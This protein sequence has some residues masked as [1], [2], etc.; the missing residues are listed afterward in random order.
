MD[1]VD[2][3]F[4]EGDGLPRPD[5]EAIYLHVEEHLKEEEQN[6]LW[7]DIART[8]MD[9]LIQQMEGNYARHES[10]NFI[11]VT[12]E[13]DRY[14]SL[15]LKFLEGNLKKIKSMLPGIVSDEGYGKYVVIVFDNDD[16][17]YNYVMWFYPEKGEFGG[18][19]GMYINRGY[20]HFVFPHEE[21]TYAESVAA[22][23]M[24][25]ALLV[26]LPIPLWLNEGL[27]VSVENAITPSFSERMDQHMHSRHQS[28]WGPEEIQQ[29]WSGDAF[30]RPDKGQELSYHLA[31][32]AVQTLSQDYDSFV[33]FV[34]K[35]NYEDAGENAATEVFGSSLGN[36]L[37]PFVGEGNWSPKPDVWP[38]AN[39]TKVSD[40]AKAK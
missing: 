3:Y 10:D 38:Q 2:K 32:F 8:W 31:Q 21:L 18:S 37:I 6:T 22:H 14:V 12:S 24:T 26:H 30:I 28:F 23:E 27:A 39:E 1:W 35:A 4:I 7:C 29:F 16:H 34:N 36:L 15:F 40:T 20:G 17:Y 19:S 25:H 5:W 13:D 33:Q 11:L 9:R